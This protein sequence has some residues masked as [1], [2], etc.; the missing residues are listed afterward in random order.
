MLSLYWGLLILRQ[1]HLEPTES[2]YKPYYV[3]PI[4]IVHYRCDH[5]MKLESMKGPYR[6]PVKDFRH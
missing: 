2:A 4:Y 1:D 5:I 6:T 3:T